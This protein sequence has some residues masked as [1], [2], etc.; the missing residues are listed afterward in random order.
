MKINTNLWKRIAQIA[1][2]FSFVVC[3]ILIINFIQLKKVNPTQTEII[4][5]LVEKLN[6]NPDTF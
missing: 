4:N 2:A 1:G 5:S 3:I 6:K